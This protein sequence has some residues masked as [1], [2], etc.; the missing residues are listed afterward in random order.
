MSSTSFDTEV[1]VAGVYHAFY[2]GYHYAI[3]SGNGTHVSS[4]LVPPQKKTCSAWYSKDA[5]DGI[6]LGTPGCAPP[7]LQLSGYGQTFPVIFELAAAMA[8]P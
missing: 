3:N 8:S 6:A 2:I 5:R 1:A 7:K 4:P